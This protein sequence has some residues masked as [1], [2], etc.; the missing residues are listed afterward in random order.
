MKILK[1]T[2]TL[3]LISIVFIVCLKKYSKFT[4]SRDLKNEE[5][6]KLKKSAEVLNECFDLKNKSQ[7]TLSDS[8]KLIEYCLKKYGYEK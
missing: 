2:F 3:I 7:R 1:I 6:N 8:M 4:I 5:K